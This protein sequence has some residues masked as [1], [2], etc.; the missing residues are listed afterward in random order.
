LDQNCGG[1]NWWVEKVLVKRATL[2]LSV[3]PANPNPNSVGC[4]VMRARH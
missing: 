3:W 1:F 2:L 4:T